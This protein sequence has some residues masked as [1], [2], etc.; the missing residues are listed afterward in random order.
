MY[1][2]GCGMMMRNVPH[3][4]IVVRYGYRD[5]ESERLPGDA[6]SI[7]KGVCGGDRLPMY[8][9]SVLTKTDENDGKRV[10]GVGN[11]PLTA[12]ILPCLVVCVVFCFRQH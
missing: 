7:L 4:D 5:G 3:Q 11:A 12:G 9:D 8:T 2:W 10:L 1:A 6:L